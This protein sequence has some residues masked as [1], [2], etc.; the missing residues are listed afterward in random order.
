MRWLMNGSESVNQD[1]RLFSRK[2][3]ELTGIEE[4]ESF[5]ENSIFMR[6]S[7]GSLSVEGE[8]LKIESFSTDKGE[9]YIDGKID[10]IYYYGNESNE[11][12]GF[13]SRFVK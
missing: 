6:S 7:M 11:K 3:M 10:S 8:N 9:L 2:R 5:T 1:I 12:R 4:V 13:F